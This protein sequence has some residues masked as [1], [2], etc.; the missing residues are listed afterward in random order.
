MI[1]KNAAEQGQ[2]GWGKKNHLL[3]NEWTAGCS[4]FDCF[5]FP[6]QKEVGLFIGMCLTHLIQ[7]KAGW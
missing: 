5:F 6:T 7:I 1:F 4:A 3:S 2:P